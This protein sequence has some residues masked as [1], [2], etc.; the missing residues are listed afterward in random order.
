VPAQVAPR[1]HAI[2]CRITSEDPRNGFLP[3]TGRIEYL[4]VPAGPGV[5]WDGGVEA[6][7]DV[8]LSYDPLLAKLIVWGETRAEALK[9]MRRA[10]D[11]LM[12]VGL[13]T[14]QPFHQLVLSE[15]TFVSG[16]YDIGYMERTGDA[17]V[18]APFPNDVIETAA[19]AAAMASMSSDRPRAPFLRMVA[20]PVRAHGCSGAK[21]R[22]PCA[23][24]D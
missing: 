6:G 24:F 11:E 5:R 15:P 2:E 10:L 7:D 18:H 20:V 19:V 21:G 1:G 8:G 17:L 9:R 3:A 16:K 4:R 23:R 13:P 14:S 22:A 12:I